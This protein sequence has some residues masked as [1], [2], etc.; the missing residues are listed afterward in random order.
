MYQ[1]R[2]ALEG[3]DQMKH[4][5]KTELLLA[6]AITVFTGAII[7]YKVYALDYTMTMIRPE[8]GYFV[9]LIMTVTGNGKDCDVRV[10]LPI[11]SDRQTIKYERESSGG[12]FKYTIS[13]GRIG[14]WRADSLSGDHDITYSY[15]AQTQAR[16]FPL[17]EGEPIPASYADFLAE[18]LAPSQDIQSDAPEIAAKARE[19]APDGVD[20]RTALQNI[21]NYCYTTVRYVKVSGPTSALTALKLEEASCNGKNRLMVAL[22]RARGIPA[23]MANGLILESSRKRTTHAWTEARIGKTWVPFC[24]TNG[25][26]AEIPD[27]YL[28][29]A[30]G[31]V[32]VFTHTAHIGFDWRFIVQ[33]QLSKED[34]VVFS[35]ANNPLNILHAWT[36]LKDY[37]I[38]LSLIMIILM[39]P[40]GATVVAFSR[41]II[42]LLP[43]GTFMPALIAVSFRDTGLWLGG[44]FLVVVVVVG[45][46]LN[47]GLMR[48]RLLHVPRLVIIIT[49]VVISILCLS[50]VCLRAGIANGAA[51]SLF[52]MAILSLTCERFTLTLLEDGWKDAARRMVSTFVVASACYFVYNIQPLQMVIVAFPE[53]LFCNIAI[54]LVMGSWTGMRLTEYYRFRSLVRSGPPPEAP[55]DRRD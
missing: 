52:P 12:A 11:Q 31:D 14:R 38:S 29:L 16:K 30:K 41:N 26:L 33:H 8:D 47:V 35:N 54:A 39:I 17:P 1:C 6:L 51:V 20:I 23:R 18:Y 25:Y 32:A 48:L 53:L 28:E 42:G 24:P 27:N 44:L 2:D 7:A 13:P 40:I 49:F 37:H 3:G 50:L 55:Q 9:R 22:L 15:F 43:F 34:D 45:C 5:G 4:L 46:V 21:Y 36:S 10:T 19:L